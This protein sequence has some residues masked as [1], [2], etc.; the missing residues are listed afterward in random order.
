[1]PG[2]GL[3]PARPFPIGTEEH[4]VPMSTESFSTECYT[5]SWTG[6]LP[7]PGDRSRTVVPYHLSGDVLG[8][9]SHPER[10]SRRTGRR[11]RLARLRTVLVLPVPARRRL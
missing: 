5:S 6:M 1:M 2:A 7:L 4:Y 3:E 8:A 10:A 11:P 9:V